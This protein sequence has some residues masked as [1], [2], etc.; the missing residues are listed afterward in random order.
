MSYYTCT[1]TVETPDS[2]YGEYF[3]T[4]EVIGMDGLSATMDENEYWFLNPTVALKVDGDLT[5]SDVRPGSVSYSD[6]ILV[7]NDADEG[8]GVL[9]DMF[10]SGTDFYDPSSSDAKC[11]TSNRLKLSLDTRSQASLGAGTSSGTTFTTD[12]TA[13]SIG[14]TGTDNA[15]HICYFATNGAYS[16]AG[17]GNADTEGYKPI[18]YSNEF[19]R[20]FYNDAEIIT[21]STPGTLRIGGGFYHHGNVLTPGA[22]QALTFK[23][24]LPEPCIGDF[25]AGQIYFWGE[26]I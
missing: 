21:E 18:V 25:S 1:F 6:T 19:T 12:C 26:A 10:I 11:P 3:L 13:D 24:A 9:M 15:D 2:M 20:D 14:L 5:F 16:T 7:G 17:A 22:E 23:L 4:A 8:S